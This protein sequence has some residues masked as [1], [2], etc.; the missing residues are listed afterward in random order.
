MQRMDLRD[1]IEAARAARGVSIHRLA[2][3]SGLSRSGLRKVRSPGK[4][5]PTIDTI[6]RLANAL[7]VSPGWLAF[8]DAARD[9]DGE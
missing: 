8:G 5:G 4:A 6:R 7:G 9:Q 2:A 1:R 3:A